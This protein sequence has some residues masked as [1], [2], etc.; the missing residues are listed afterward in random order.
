MISEFVRG[1]IVCILKSKSMNTNTPLIP[2]EP[3]A[4]VDIVVAPLS[5]RVYFCPCPGHG[6]SRNFFL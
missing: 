1:I 2:C 4:R 5:A 6:D 3:P